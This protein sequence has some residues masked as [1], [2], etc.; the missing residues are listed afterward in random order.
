MAFSQRDG[1]MS[2]DVRTQFQLILVISLADD[3]GRGWLLTRSS[4]DFTDA[5]ID[6]A[7][8]SL[9]VLVMLD[10]IAYV[11]FRTTLPSKSKHTEQRELQ[12]LH[13][14]TTGITANAIGITEATVRKHAEHILPE[15]ECPL[16]GRVLFGA[17]DGPH[18]LKGHWRWLLSIS[19]GQ[20]C[21]S[22]HQLQTSVA[23]TR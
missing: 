21:L 6:T 18:A 19:S 23:G 13:L 8:L 4:M 10:R 11:K 17:E 14:L 12:V 2:K 16:C 20:Q 15:L 1:E 5:D 3:I 9:P 7:A 22:C